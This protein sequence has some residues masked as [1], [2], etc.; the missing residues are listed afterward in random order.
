M[1]RSRIADSSLLLVAM[2]WGCT[3][4][5]VQNAVKVLPPLAFNSIRFMGAALLL[6]LITV[7]FYRKDWK[8]LSFLMVRDSLLLGLFLFMGYGFQTMGLLYTTTSNTGFITG[9]SV[10]LV[11]F[12]S[13]ALLKHAI[14]RYTWFSAALAAI[15]LYLL[16]FTGSAL[17]LNKGDA[18]ILLCAIAFA[19]QVAYT[20]VYAPHYPALPLATLQL[21]FV[22][23]FSIAASLIFEGATPLA[24]SGELIKDP[25]VLWA[26]LI[27]I[28]PTSAFAFWIQT[29]CQKY[30]TPS[31]VAIIYATE[32]VFAVLTGLAFGGE[33]LGL[34]ALLGCGCI[35]GAMLMAELSPEPGQNQHKKSYF[36]KLHLFRKR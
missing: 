1:K 9:L 25:D 10:V 16:T 34:S 7:I 4:L 2:M 32:P 35:L 13:L 23:L 8:Q 17:S 5:I 11:P 36:S 12:L 22:G 28:G 14:S 31:R 18:L 29:A 3:F 26:L 20:G 6:A 21:A 30:T 15:G 27:S 24:H 19:L 33:T